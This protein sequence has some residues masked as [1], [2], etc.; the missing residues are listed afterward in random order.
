MLAISPATPFPFAVVRCALVVLA[1][2]VCTA[3]RA[4]A[5]QEEAEI[6]GTIAGRIVDAESGRPLFGAL[7]TIEGTDR[8]VLSDAE[9]RFSLSRMLAG[10]HEIMVA[11][12][13]YDTLRIGAITGGD[14]LRLALD[15]NPVLL[16]GI[17]VVTDRFRRRRNAV[18]TSV[19]AFDREQLLVSASSDAREFVSRNAGLVPTSCLGFASPTPCAWVRGRPQPIRVYIDDNPTVGGLDHLA[20]YQPHELY[21]VEVFAGGRHIRAYTNWY[22]S[23]AASRKLLPQP[24]IFF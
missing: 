8:G 20:M 24:L 23:H 14:P 19:R 21:L 2:L 16:E 5:Q 15:P 17:R 18:A 13:G 1:V 22:M 11:Q 6:A 12:L 7:V 10:E 4:E 3:P 9:G